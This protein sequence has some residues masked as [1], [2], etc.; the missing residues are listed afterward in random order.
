MD[1]WVWDWDLCVGLLYEHLFAVLLITVSDMHVALQIFSIGTKGGTSGGTIAG[2]T[3]FW[4]GLEPA[5]TSFGH[6]Y[7]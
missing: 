6:S 2:V 3:K 5:R 7:G 1:G 4:P